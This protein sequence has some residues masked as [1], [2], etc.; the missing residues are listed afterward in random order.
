MKTNPLC[1]CD[2]CG[3]TAR[4]DTLP[5]AKDVEER[6]ADPRDEFS[7]VECPK[8]GALCFEIPAHTPE[9]WHYGEN[10]NKA[11]MGPIVVPH[12]PGRPK[13]RKILIAQFGLY[14]DEE[15]NAEANAKRAIACVNALAGLNP[16]AVRDVVEVLERL[17][18]LL[19]RT[20]ERLGGYVALAKLK[21]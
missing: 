14:T 13:G 12:K 16:E 1:K 2:N 5:P 17:G 18:K 9:P 10:Y 4:Y 21:S 3:Y 19:P 11:I 8:C 7:D 20:M 6:C 15:A